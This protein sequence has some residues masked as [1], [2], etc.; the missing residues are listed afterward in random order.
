MHAVVGIPCDIK[1]VGKHP[2]HA[3][4]AKYIAAVAG[5]AHCLPLLLPALGEAL[6][7]SAALDQF[8]GVLLT[9]SLSNV[10][11]WRYAGA[12]SRADTL[13]DP[14]R[15][16]TTLPLIRE[17]VARGMPLLGICRGFQEINVAL[18]GTLHQHVQEQPGLA[19]HRDLFG[20]VP[21]EVSYGLSHS[22]QL[23]RGG[24]LARTLGVDDI[25][26]NSLHQQGVA[27]LAPGLCAEA[28]A[29]DGLIE[30]FS[31]P[32]APGWLFAVQWHPEWLYETNA[33]SLALFEAFGAACRQYRAGRTGQPASPSPQGEAR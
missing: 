14:A 26:V 6:P 20:D 31:L 5:G 23:V 13:H 16:A 3:A 33:A 24:R 10:E 32:D 7:L 25:Q 9:G 30:A 18:G 1:P 28:H 22:V 2:F 15:D 17:V 29:P 8:D 21:L 27:T 4:G 11:P 19:D 12:P